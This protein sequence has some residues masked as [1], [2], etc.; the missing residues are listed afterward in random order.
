MFLPTYN[1]ENSSQ[2]RDPAWF[3]LGGARQHSVP[4][5]GAG[6]QLGVWSLAGAE[7]GAGCDKLFCNDHTTILY[8]HGQTGHRGT[9]YRCIDLS[10][11]FCRYYKYFLEGWVCTAC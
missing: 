6:E 5:G 8:L 2:L 1:A 7:T 4:V 11:I 3:Q 9:H 10:N